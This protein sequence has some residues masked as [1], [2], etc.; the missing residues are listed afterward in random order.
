MTITKEPVIGYTPIKQLKKAPSKPTL[1]H[2]SLFVAVSFVI[3]PI[4]Q[5]P[6]QVGSSKCHII[7]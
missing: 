4:L 2:I 7:I 5:R 3:N 1:K 6:V